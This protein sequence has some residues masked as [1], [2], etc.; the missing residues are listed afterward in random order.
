MSFPQLSQSWFFCRFTT[1]FYKLSQNESFPTHVQFSLFPNSLP[2]A[3]TFVFSSSFFCWSLFCFTLLFITLQRPPSHC[4]LLI[5]CSAEKSAAARLF[6]KKMTRNAAD[7]VLQRCDTMRAV[8]GF[9][10]CVK[11]WAGLSFL[12]NLFKWLGL[13]LCIRR[14]QVQNKVF[15]SLGA[16]LSI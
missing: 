10:A 16:F 6:L 14:S 5:P 3:F 8:G 4:P 12:A 1:Y 2:Y 7:S 9:T 13:I 11:I 15:D